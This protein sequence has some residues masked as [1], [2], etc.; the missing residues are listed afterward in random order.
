MRTRS[1]FAL[2]FG[3]VMAVGCSKNT[4][5][6]LELTTTPFYMNARV[7]G[8]DWTSQGSADCPDPSILISPTDTL[9]F[10]IF[11]AASCTEASAFQGV[12]TEFTGPGIYSLVEVNEFLEEGTEEAVLT[13]FYDATVGFLT[14]TDGELRVLFYKEPS[15]SNPGFVDIIFSGTVENEAGTITRNITHGE[16]RLYIQ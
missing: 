8:A 1:L 12:I 3:V 7:N 5:D 2:A 6:D 16:A 13:F 15:G 14:S 10:A 11:Q 4:V 9:P